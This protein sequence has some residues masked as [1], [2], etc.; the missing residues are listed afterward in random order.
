MITGHLHY[1]T[2]LWAINPSWTNTGI[3]LSDLKSISLWTTVYGR[4]QLPRM[5]PKRTKLAVEDGR[6]VGVSWISVRM[7]RMSIISMEEYVKVIWQ[8]NHPCKCR[9]CIIPY[10]VHLYVLFYAE[11][12][13]GA[14]YCSITEVKWCVDCYQRQFLAYLH[15]DWPSDATD[16]IWWTYLGYI[17]LTNRV[18]PLNNRV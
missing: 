10:E 17:A 8:Q 5:H 11:W 13:F 9:S 3:Q 15:Q 4:T 6:V 7:K 18:I 16:A 1:F 2:V 14:H 12:P